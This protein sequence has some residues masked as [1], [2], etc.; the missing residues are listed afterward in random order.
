[1]FMEHNRKINKAK[2]PASTQSAGVKKLSGNPPLPEKLED[3][4]FTPNMSSPEAINRGHYE[5]GISGDGIYG[6]SYEDKIPFVGND[7][8]KNPIPLKG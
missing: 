1:M 7:Q 3:W 6:T 5:G 8:D 4:R 2:A